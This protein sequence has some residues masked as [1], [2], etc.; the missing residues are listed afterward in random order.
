MY[1]GGVREGGS[2]MG[3]PC[4]ALKQANLF[5]NWVFARNSSTRAGC[6]MHAQ[7]AFCNSLSVQSMGLDMACMHNLVLQFP[8]GAIYGAGCGM[9]AQPA[10]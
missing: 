8:F 2:V 7:P 5:V 4:I 1:D 3:R 6:G 10:F 9:H